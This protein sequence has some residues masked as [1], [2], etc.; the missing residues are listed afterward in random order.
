MKR[1]LFTLAIFA[2]MYVFRTTTAYALTVPKATLDSLVVDS[3]VVLI[4]TV[5]G[6]HF[7]PYG[8]DKR[9]YTVYS[10]RL[11]EIVYGKEQLPGGLEREIQLPV[12]G[13][14]NPNDRITTVV[15]T[16]KLAMGETYLLFLRGGTWSLNP[17]SGWNQGAF[18]LVFAG[19]NIGHVVLSLDGKALMDVRGDQ[20]MFQAPDFSRG[21]PDGQRPQGKRGGDVQLKQ[22]SLPKAQKGLSDEE[23]L[24]ADRE[25]LALLERRKPDPEKALKMDR[26]EQLK[27]WLGDQPMTLKA[28]VEIVRERRAKLADQI[29]KDK[30]SFSFEPVP[31]TGQ[32]MAPP[33]AETPAR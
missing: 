9:P 30:R 18:R 3:P 17:V 6:Q 14:L 7:R 16:T 15:G 12:F 4:G 33:K 5:V 23:E 2:V 26:G 10:L 11:Q 22:G 21:R 29:P 13:G 8:E 20:L 31:P 27:A 32:G 25:R 28:F 19:P 1:A 24:A